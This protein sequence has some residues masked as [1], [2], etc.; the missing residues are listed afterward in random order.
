MTKRKKT[1]KGLLSWSEKKKTV[2][3][4]RR[5]NPPSINARLISELERLFPEYKVIVRYENA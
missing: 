4:R 5:L 2:T 3:I 1:Y